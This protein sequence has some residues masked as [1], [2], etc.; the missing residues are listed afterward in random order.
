MKTTFDLAFEY[1][2]QNEGGDRFTNDPFD[3]GGA[4]KYGV[5]KH[6]YERY[7]GREVSISEIQN[8][9]EDEAK[10]FYTDVFWRPLHLDGIAA[11]A[12]AIAI[13]DT[14]VLYG[15]RYAA[16]AAQD[17]ANQKGSSLKLDGVLGDKSR[18]AINSVPSDDFLIRYH[19]GI[20]NRIDLVVRHDSKNEVF[21]K[22]WKTRAERLLK[23]TNPLTKE[24]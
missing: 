7:L 9:T 2:M 19:I 4:T 21:Q 16:R 17:V 5:T 11:P 18:A 20:L 10:Q 22:G 6:S 1:T 8:L 3:S 24:A 15:P 13:F 14:G 12:V 23:L